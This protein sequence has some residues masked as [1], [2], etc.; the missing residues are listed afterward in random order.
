VSRFQKSAEVFSN[1][2]LVNEIELI[3]RLQALGFDI[4]APEQMDFRTQIQAFAQSDIVIGPGGAG[5]FNCVFC[6]PGATIVTIE[7]NANWVAN[8]CALFGSLGLN[9]S[10]VFGQ[11]L[12]AAKGPHSPW[13]LDVDGF[14][15]HLKRTKS[16]SL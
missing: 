4:V 14:L 2:V 1:R 9:Y 5:M 3:I 12:D 16:L 13:R 8:H 11:Q 10:V 6:R 7:S 15:D